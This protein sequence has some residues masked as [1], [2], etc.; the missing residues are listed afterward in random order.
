MTSAIGIDDFDFENEKF[1]PEISLPHTVPQ[2]RAD[3]MENFM[4][5]NTLAGRAVPVSSMDLD[6]NHSVYVV[7]SCIRVKIPSESMRDAKS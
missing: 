1:R 5:N 2:Y 7:D 3:W 6:P 4:K